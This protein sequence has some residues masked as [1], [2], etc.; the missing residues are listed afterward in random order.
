MITPTS[1]E[2]RELI[3][4]AERMGIPTED[5]VQSVVL[6]VPRTRPGAVTCEF[7]VSHL[8]PTQQRQPDPECAPP[9]RSTEAAR[10]S[11]TAQRGPR[12]DQAR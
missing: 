8:R 1:S 7:V 5:A 2:A 11:S 3:G 10:F 9:V 6:S 4:L 12:P